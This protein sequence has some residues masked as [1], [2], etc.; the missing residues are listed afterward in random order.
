VCPLLQVPLA[1]SHRSIGLCTDAAL[2]ITLLGGW[3]VPD[4]HD[5]LQAAQACGGRSAVLLLEHLYEPW[6]EWLQQQ[7]AVVA[8]HA[9]NFEHMF[10]YDT[11]AHQ[12][13]HV[14]LCK[15]QRCVQ[16]LARYL[17]DIGST[18][19]LMY[20]GAVA[21]VEMRQQEPARAV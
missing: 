3:L 14:V 9:P 10:A 16:L 15:V 21:G 18:A 13:M 2:Y 1:A 8:V 20:T 5:G 4:T 19:A 11:G 12:R 17:A 7:P 6:V